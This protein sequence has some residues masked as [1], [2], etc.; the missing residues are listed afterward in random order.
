[1][2]EAF[3]CLIDKLD[4]AR[5]HEL[6][7]GALRDFAASIGFERFAYLQKE[8]MRVRTLSSYPEPWKKIYLE[9]HLVRIDPVVREARLRR[10]PFTW[11]ADQWKSTD[12]REMRDFRN[13]AISHGIRSGITVAVEGSFASTLMLTLA[14]PRREIATTF[15]QHG[16]KAIQALL[17]VHY[18]SLVRST[19]VDVGPRQTLSPKELL[20]VEWAARGRNGPQIADIL[21]MSPRTV[22]DH[23][24]KARRKAAASTVPHLIAIAKDR[25]WL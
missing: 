15:S 8:G 2:D 16:A 18:R 20:C 5:G 14:S 25:S 11:S 6:M 23:L 24:D 3:R 12:D 22:Q 17:S 13:E 21:G 1:M 9:R 4:S 7:V 10:E 19:R